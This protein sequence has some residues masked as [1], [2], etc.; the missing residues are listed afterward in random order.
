MH[1]HGLRFSE[2]KPDGM[3]SNIFMYHLKQLMSGGY[4]IKE[5]QKYQL[6][7]KGLQYVDGLSET[8][9]KPRKQ[10]KV[11]AIIALQNSEGQWLLGQRKIQPYLDKLVLP[12]GKQHFGESIYDHAKR[13]LVEKTGLDIP[14]TY[15]GIASV[16][17]KGPNETISHIIGHVHSGVYDNDLPSET[18]KL[19][20]V[21][22]DFVDNKDLLAG[23]VEIYEA[24]GKDNQ[25]FMIDL[26]LWARISLSLL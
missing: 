19:K 2:L 3:E 23:T 8:N 22:H 26:N 1:S 18:K 6:S 24:L 14:L 9:F 10:P 7:D 11:V 21:W 17:I 20:F 16:S 5:L 15:R 12:S 4:V 13:E 25:L